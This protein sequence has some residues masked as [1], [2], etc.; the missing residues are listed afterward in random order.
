[1]ATLLAGFP[2]LSLLL[3][4]P[5]AGAVLLWMLPARLARATAVVVAVLELL[6]AGGLVGAVHPGQAG[7]QWVERFSWMPTVNAHYLLGVDGLSVLFLP[8]SALLFVAVLLSSR[9]ESRLYFALLLALEG[10]TMG[11][12]CALDTLLFFLF[13]ELTLVPLYFLVTLWGIGPQRRFAA[14]QYTLF[15]L[16]GGALLLFGFLLVANGVAALHAVP[17]A[18]LPPSSL[19]FD[20][21]SLLANP[22]PLDRQWPVFLLLLAGFAVKT[23]VVPFHVWLPTLAMEGPVAVVAIMTGIKL[24]AYG[25]L[26]FALPLAPQAAQEWHWLLAGL[27]V[28]GI[29]YGGLAALAQTNLRRMLA[30]SSVSH[31]GLVLLGLSTLTVQG[32][33]GAVLQLLNF[34][35]MAGGLFLLA[36]FVRRRTDSTELVQLGGLVR[37][38]PMATTFFLLFGL[39]SMGL[40]LTSGFP[41]E[42]LIVLGAM[43]VHKGAALAAIGGQILGAAYFLHYYRRAFLGPV[44]HPVVAAAADLTRWEG[45]AVLLLAIPVLLS[46]F[47]PQWIVHFTQTA[48]V[49]WVARFSGAMP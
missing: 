47:Y 13:W 43:T 19:V 37:A 27:G 1:M 41:A 16:G 20:L 39:A 31:V 18:V 49:R 6:L 25:L 4:L 48:A 21:P 5:L 45:V 36:G 44:R 46:G 10:I 8:C 29:F 35:V 22:L 14:I 38:M 42:Q 32:V 40:P 2:L 30:F 12:F 7:F 34:T 9:L 17:N 23:P 11:I 3:G 24:G 15:M 33:Q 26:R 28:V